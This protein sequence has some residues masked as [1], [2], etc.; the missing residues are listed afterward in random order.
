MRLPFL[1]KAGLVIISLILIWRQLASMT[2]L[3][4]GWPLNDFSVYMKGVEHTFTGNPYTQKFFD[5]YNY[6]PAATLFFYPLSLLPIDTSEFIFTGLSILSLFLSVLL[7]FKLTHQK[8]HFYMLFALSYLLLR[9]A[10]TRLTLTLGQIN[11]IV[12]LLILLAFY[13][14]K[15][16]QFISGIVLALAFIFKFTPIFLLLFFILKKQGKVILGFI[17]TVILLHFL[18]ILAFGWDLTGYYYFEV[19][20]KLLIQTGLYTA[21]LTYMN[22]SLTALLGRLGIFDLYHTLIKLAAILPLLWLLSRRRLDFTTYALFLVFMTIF[23]PTFAWQHHYVFLI[24]AI[25]LLGLRHW[26]LGTSLY[27]L[28]NLTISASFPAYANPFIHSQSFFSAVAM[29]V[30]IFV[31]RPQSFPD[32]K[33]IR[34]KPGG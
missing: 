4:R 30:L 1:A 5:Y 22:Q 31:A 7:L 3:I 16:R 17:D 29:F 32:R 8:L 21:Q 33:L 13:F 34:R 20:P 27:L 11:L 24:P 15:K 14:S 10:P 6:P 18:A 23:L 26:A 19:L 9:F 2:Q 25:F 12:L 28:L